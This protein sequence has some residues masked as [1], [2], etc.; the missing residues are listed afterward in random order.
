[1]IAEHQ[2][3]F[4]AALA[5]HRAAYTLSEGGMDEGERALVRVGIGTAL[6]L[7]G[8][9]KPA[10]VELE[11][12]LAAAREAWGAHAPE[13]GRIAFNL[14]MLAADLGEDEVAERHLEAAISIDT[15]AW[16]EDSTE[17]A[18]ARSGAG[19]RSRTPTPRRGDTGRRPGSSSGG[20]DRQSCRSRAVPAAELL[21]GVAHFPGAAHTRRRGSRGID[22]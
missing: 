7:S 19:A 5:A 13:V 10:R 1:M 6:H 21:A 8:E 12:S 11:A 20:H 17:V 9:L 22:S 18:R 3:N 15:A 14:A 4:P 2:G 16:G